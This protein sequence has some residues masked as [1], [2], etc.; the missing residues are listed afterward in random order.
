VV[1]ASRESSANV[2]AM[3]IG[4]ITTLLP[5]GWL[6]AFAVVAGGTGSAVR[7]A[8]VMAA[9]WVGTV[10]M[11]L[12][13]GAGAARLL[14]PVARRLPLVSAGL[15]LTLGVLSVAGKLRPPA[16]PSQYAHSHAGMGR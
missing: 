3:L 5:C 14:G 4:L 2:R 8:A 1:L 15:V 11:L 9:F 6:Y 13:F 12:L 16:L 10:P 7:G